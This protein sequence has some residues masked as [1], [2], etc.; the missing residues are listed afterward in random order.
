MAIIQGQQK[1]APDEGAENV[2][3]PAPRA[4]E[5]KSS[6]ASLYVEFSFPS[7]SS[8]SFP[9]SFDADGDEDAI[10]VF[11]KSKPPKSLSLPSL[12]VFHLGFYKTSNPNAFLRPSFG[13][14]R[15]RF[16]RKRARDAHTHT[17]RKRVVKKQRSRNDRQDKDETCR[18]CTRS[19][20]TARDG[21]GSI[22]PGGR[23]GAM[24]RHRRL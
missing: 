10:S 20:G 24:S 15:K 16:W 18:F 23:E 11:D 1:K 7:S 3:T 17:K 12:F 22:C 2:F 8:S 19:M 9:L 4:R 5:K 6:V 13:Q 21:R 14:R